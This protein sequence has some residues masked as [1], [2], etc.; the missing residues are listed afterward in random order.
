LRTC[1]IIAIALGLA[2]SSAF[3]ATLNPPNPLSLSEVGNTNHGIEFTTLDDSTLTSFIYNCQGDAD[4]VELTTG[5]GTVLDMTSIPANGGTNP[6]AFTASVNWSLLSGNVY[7]LIGTTP[8]NGLFGGASYP[9]SD[10]DISVTSGIFSSSQTSSFWSDFSE[11]TT[12]ST[13]NVPEG[14]L[15]VPTLAALL[16]MLAVKRGLRFHRALLTRMA[17]FNRS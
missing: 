10:A 8:S 11:I 4:T 17:R 13:S 15:A 1:S 5:T 16:S 14:Y 9:V 3:S 7:R 12:T 6:S 2:G